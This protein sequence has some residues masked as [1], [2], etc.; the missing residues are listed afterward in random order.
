MPESLPTDFE[1]R[2]SLAEYVAA[3]SPWRTPT[4]PSP[5]RGGRRAALERLDAIWADGC[6]TGHQ[7]KTFVYFQTFRANSAEA[8][9]VMRRPLKAVL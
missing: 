5:F 8:R 2:R 1:S 4:E 3:I 9:S 6:S 7:G